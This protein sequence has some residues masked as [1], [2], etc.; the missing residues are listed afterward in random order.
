MECCSNIIWLTFNESVSIL[1][2]YQ[3]GF[4]FLLICFGIGI[5]TYFKEYYLLSGAIWS[6]VWIFVTGVIGV[7][8]NHELHKIYMALNIASIVFSIVNMT[9]FSIGL[10]YVKL[11]SVGTQRG[12]QQRH[13]VETSWFRR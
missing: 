3:I 7:V 11:F 13:D 6:G 2:I 4:G 9:I 1:G 10:K 8:N 12:L 5:V